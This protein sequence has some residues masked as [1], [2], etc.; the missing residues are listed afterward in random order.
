MSTPS[1]RTRTRGN[2]EARPYQRKSDGKWVATYYTE[3]GKRHP[4]YG[5]TRD[6]VLEKRK[7]AQREVDDNRP[8]TVGKRD[9][10]T[11][12]LNEVWLKETLPQRVLAGHLGPRSLENDEW[13]VKHH[14]IPH[15]GH[16]PLVELGPRHIR[17]WLLELAAK[18]I[19]QQPKDRPK[20]DPVL[21]ATGSIA[22]IH[23]VLSGALK[24][25]CADG[26]LTQNVCALVHPPT[27]TPSKPKRVLTKDEVRLLLKA[28]AEHRLWAYWVTL[29][30]LGLR[31]GEGLGMRWSDLDLVAGTVS[32]EEQLLIVKG[33][34]NP[35]TGRRKN[36]VV[37]AKLKTKASHDTLKLPELTRLALLEHQQE[38]QATKDRAPVWMDDTLVFTNMIGEQIHPAYASQMWRGICEAAG[39]EPCGPKTL[40]HACGTFLFADGVDMKVIQGLLRHTRKATT[41]EVYVHLLKEVTDGA[42]VTMNGVLI[43]L[44][45][46]KKR[47]SEAVATRAAT[48]GA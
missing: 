11:T 7:T 44:G 42:S 4:V 31:R 39:V 10:L 46:E 13:A 43:D 34:K 3:D 40:R 48:S 33:A 18:P 32:L 1:R 37:K 2:R 27:I 21:L 9:K 23:S 24:D 28:A 12:Y 29:L 45:A 25:A 8:I 19:Q 5:A 17:R 16:V 38:Q 22:R 26:I 15:L 41:E 35:K 6:D 20:D 36:N 30:G 14:I 47:R